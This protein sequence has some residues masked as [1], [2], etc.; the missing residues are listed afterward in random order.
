MNKSFVEGVPSLFLVTSPLQALCAIEAIAR[1]KITD[2]KF[3]LVLVDNEKRNDQV[4]YVCRKYNVEYTVV[5]A[6]ISTRDWF[7]V[8]MLT[9]RYY[10]RAFIGNIRQLSHIYYAVRYLKFHSNVVC[11]DD[12]NDTI[13]LLNNGNISDQISKKGKIRFS[14]L[15]ICSYFLG[16]SYGCDLF[17]IYG[18]IYNK[19]YH[20]L[21]NDFSYV[22]H[23][24]NPN[25]KQEG[26]F[27][28]GTNYDR[29]CSEENYPLDIVKNGLRT[30]LMEIKSKYYG[31]KIYYIP[32]GLDTADF[33]QKI[34]DELEIE[35]IRPKSTVELMIINNETIPVAIYGFTSTA[36]Y[37]LFLLYPM[38]EVYNIKFRVSH[39]N[40]FIEQVDIVS[41]YYKEHGIT[42]IVMS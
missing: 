22:S 26:V 42:E 27:F 28:I 36:L 12:G 15:K 4:I 8:I 23:G 1:F 3:L 21:L 13:F 39:M 17:T 6:S 40:S 38:M 34:C 10:N 30:A 33:P 19:K 41:K 37:N 25:K 31:Q 32:H 35:V 29:Y 18:D 11:M 5:P 16:I 9:D 20:T 14:M 7:K 24:L 2:Y